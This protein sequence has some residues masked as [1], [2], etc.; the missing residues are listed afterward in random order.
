M[1]EAR[2]CVSCKHVVFSPSLSFSSLHYIHTIMT[3]YSS[4]MF[5]LLTLSRRPSARF[6]SSSSARYTPCLC[7]YAS[8][9]LIDSVTY[10]FNVQC[11][12][13]NVCTLYMGY[14]AVRNT[15]VSALIAQIKT[16]LDHLCS[17]GPNSVWNFIR[18]RA[19][20]CRG[21]SRK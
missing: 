18:K 3:R 15:Y 6:A 2:I 16:R 17:S 19:Q 1:R 13:V 9:L 5:H 8:C 14:T 10:D 4:V 21:V 20:R 12:L 11:P 7:A